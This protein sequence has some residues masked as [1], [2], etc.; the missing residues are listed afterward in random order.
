PRAA[1]RV[2]YESTISSEGRKKNSKSTAKAKNARK[3]RSSVKI[4]ISPSRERKPMEPYSHRFDSFIGH[5]SFYVVNFACYDR[6]IPRA[7]EEVNTN[8]GER[9]AGAQRRRH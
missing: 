3:P 1:D 9:V 8:I 4:P 5:V 2:M 6:N 7:K